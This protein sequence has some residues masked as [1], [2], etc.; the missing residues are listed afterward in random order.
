MRSPTKAEWY[1][2][3]PLLDEAMSLA[4]S[5]AHVLLAPSCGGDAELVAWIDRFLDGAADEA[6]PVTLAPEVVASAMAFDD[7]AVPAVDA[8][9]GAYRIVRE[10]GRG[11]MGAVYLAERADGQY[12]QQVALKMV[13]G[14]LGTSVTRERF[15]RERQILARL[16]HPNVAHLV[17]G[18]ITDAG[19]SWFAMEYVDG[20]PLDAYCDRRQLQVGERLA[21]FLSVCDAV[22]AAHQ[23]LVIHRDLKPSNILVTLDGQ[24]KLLDFGI[25]RLV[26]D[27]DAGVTQT[28]LR[29]FTPEYASPE[30]WRGD[31]VT[32]GSDVYSLGVVLYEL[33]AGARP[34]ALRGHP[35]TEWPLIVLQHAV[36]PP[37]SVVS[38]RAAAARGATVDRLRRRLREELD[39]IVMTALRVESERRYRT[40][41]QL[42][43]DVRRHLAGHMIAARPDTWRYRTH[44]FVRR[45]RVGVAAGAV[46]LVSLLGGTAGVAWQAR[47]AEREATRAI[48]ARQFLAGVFRES[49]PTNARGDSLT[50]GDMLDR[51]TR[52]LDSLFVGQ[53]LVK[54]DLLMSLGE[55]Y[56]NLGRFPAADSLASRALLLADSV[57]VDREQAKA[58]A[59]IL[60]GS[61]RVDAGDLLSA[62]TLV[63]RG[64]RS[65]DRGAISDT[66]LAGALSIL[67]AIKRQQY[68]FVESDAAYRQAIAIAERTGVDS[69]TLVAYWND[70]GVMLMEA[71]RY[72]AADS[73]L[74]R[75]INYERIHL[76]ANHPGLTLTLMNRAMVRD[77]LGDKDSAAVIEAEVLRIQRHNYPRGHERV[78]EALNTLAFARM[79]GG[80]FAGADSLFREAGEMLQRLFGRDH[81]S[82]LIV[83]NNRARI[84][85]LAGHPR[86]AEVLFR[87]VLDDARRALGESH[88]YVS[89]PVHWIGRSLLAQGRPHE[90]RRML[91]S[92]LHM[93]QRTLPPEHERFADVWAALGATAIAL[94]DTT[95]ADSALQRSLSHRT[96]RAGTASV[97]ATEPMLLLARLRATEGRHAAAESLYVQAL[98]T[99][100][101]QRALAWRSA[102]ARRELESWRARWKLTG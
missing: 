34:H 84:A 98:A 6:F 97:E 100:E 46:V 83:R 51:A 86:E 81:M 31:P 61:V 25:A 91:D 85:L 9:F 74:S 16:E 71:G 15:L 65:H 47:R 13:H 59:T 56:R 57:D 45:H 52:R 42:A 39:T 60:L 89:Q 69:L 96:T 22:Q 30:Q 36:A 49:D 68:A 70:F 32:T 12:E 102:P 54:F 40:V 87:G 5:D 101:G 19:Q 37:S 63:Q 38:P 77:Y 93:A 2:L 3:E 75:T 43:S 62:D 76:P 8:R 79:D 14:G 99:L 53:P 35:E 44:K 73:A 48:A 28:G 7:P 33:L 4:R 10:L 17:D 20:E 95:A 50:A 64:I 41:E 66:A 78:A 18:G 24:V 29:A 90:A 26:H 58:T 72:Q 11:G 80:D 23:R 94:G 27:T 21:L 92:A 67:G 1:Q 88:G 82:I 55:I